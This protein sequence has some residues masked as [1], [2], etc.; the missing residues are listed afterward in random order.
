MA[1]MSRT[2]KTI[3]T[4][5]LMTI[6]V[7]CNTHPAPE[8]TETPTPTLTV[9]TTTPTTQ[10]VQHAEQAVVDLW[11]MVD[12]LVNNPKETIQKLDTVASGDAL[13][14]FQQNI[15]KY[16]AAGWKGTGSS[17]VEELEA[18][19]SG[20]NAT[21]QSTWSVTACVDG[22]GTTLVDKDGK[23]VQGPPYRIRHKATVEKR[24]SKFYVVSDEAVGT[25]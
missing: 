23:S 4:L 18:A 7:A 5:A 15:G 11:A 20:V 16:R 22:S 12:R 17:V 10:N 21:G 8:P 24:D 1:T 3:I 2:P 14:M 19:S 13:D 6:L 9:P 25:C